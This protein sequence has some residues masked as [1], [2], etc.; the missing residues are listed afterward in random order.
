MYDS[1]RLAFGK[2][3]EIF[4]KM[5]D[6]NGIPSGSQSSRLMGEEY[7]NEKTISFFQSLLQQVK[8][9]SKT[10]HHETIDQ[11]MSKIKSS[12]LAGL[13]V[14]KCLGWVCQLGQQL[15]LELD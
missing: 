12:S 7:E 15:N 11:V 14:E 6:I 8:Q 3:F 5:N 10:K 4:L 1:G 9:Q 2:S 13:D